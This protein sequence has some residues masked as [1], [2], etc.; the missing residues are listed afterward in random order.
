LNGARFSGSISFGT[1]TTIK[2]AGLFD[3]TNLESRSTIEAT[4]V[5]PNTPID[6]IYNIRPILDTTNVGVL[7][8][9]GLTTIVDIAT[10][11][12]PDTPTDYVF[13]SDGTE[14]TQSDT[15]LGTLL[16]TLAID[17]FETARPSVVSAFARINSTSL[18]GNTLAEMGLKNTAGTLLTRVTFAD[19]VKESGQVIEG[20][21][22]IDF[23]NE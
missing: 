5:E 14:A 11:E 2:E 3:G 22:Q 15:S 19:V 20:R 12:T 21:T 18:T 17:R 1:E 23:N 9:A 6:V 8:D 7:T 16:T 4:T 10:N 13:G